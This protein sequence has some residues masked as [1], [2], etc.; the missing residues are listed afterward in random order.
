[1]Y[2]WVQMQIQ[3]SIDM[4][5]TRDANGDATADVTGSCARRR[6]PLQIYLQTLCTRGGL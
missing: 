6:K 5:M 2:V 4:H 3:P 1:M